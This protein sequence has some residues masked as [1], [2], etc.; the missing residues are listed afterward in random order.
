M[1]IVQYIKGILDIPKKNRKSFIKNHFKKDVDLI[2]K[3]ISK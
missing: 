2:E 3:H 1:L